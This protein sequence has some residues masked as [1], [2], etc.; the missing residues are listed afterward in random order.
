MTKH[1]DI[2]CQT[3]I[4]NSI[5]HDTKY[6][7]CIFTP[8]NIKKN[9]ATLYILDGNSANNYI[10]DILPVIDAL[11]NPPVLVTL[12]YESWNNLSIH[13]R[14]Y[15]YTPDGENA[16]VDNSKPAW[17][18]FTGGGSQS[19][20]ELLLT[21]IMPW[22]STIAPNSSRIG[23]WGHSLGA[24]FVLDCLKNNS[25][26]NYYYI[27]APSLLWQNER[28]IKIIKDDISE[29]KHTKSIC[30]LNGNLSLDY[31]ASLYPE[32][33]KAESVLRNI[34][35]EK[36][37]NFSIVQFPELNHQE[38]FSAALWNSIIHFS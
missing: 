33:I 3:R 5:N 7:I 26:F 24:I 17:I 38:T 35:T 9:N 13:R 34:L 16:I 8:K 22:V 28:I 18:Y 11:P 19:F 1:M 30:L 32:A 20:R 15:D 37:S 6:K 14:A 27:S 36:Y 2:H 21:Q 12:G 31:S 23:I 4:F 25:C 29:S 10:S